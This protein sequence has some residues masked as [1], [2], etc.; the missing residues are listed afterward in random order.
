MCVLICEIGNRNKKCISKRPRLKFEKANQGREKK[1][2]LP[3]APKDQGKP[4]ATSFLVLT[5]FVS[6]NKAH[7]YFKENFDHKN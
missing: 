4:P 6:R 3:S 5:T 1:E 7:T 2:P